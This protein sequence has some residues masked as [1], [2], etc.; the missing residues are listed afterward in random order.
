MSE[1]TPSQTFILDS[2]VA[3]KWYLPEELREEALKLS[4]RMGAGDVELL[5]PATIGPEV[6]NALFQQHRRGHL[7]LDEVRRF[8]A[9]FDEAPISLF[10]V[11]PL[12]PRAAEISLETG[13]IIYDALFLA[14]AEE[15]NTVMVTADGKLSTALKD[16]PYARLACDLAN[17]DALIH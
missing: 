13:A 8:F 10:E 17:L 15:A 6:F 11:D 4:A 9:S 3:V 7:S 1:Q 2:S 5:A 12:T 16:T 14:L